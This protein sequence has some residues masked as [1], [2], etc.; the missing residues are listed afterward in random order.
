MNLSP[1]NQVVPIILLFPGDFPLGCNE[2]A[3]IR[4]RKTAL[5]MR[6]SVCFL[7][8]PHFQSGNVIKAPAKCQMV[9][10]KTG[11]CV[12]WRL[13]MLVAFELLVKRSVIWKLYWG[14]VCIGAYI[15]HAI[16]LYIL[17][18]IWTNLVG[19]GP[20]SCLHSTNEKYIEKSHFLPP[21]LR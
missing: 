13:I 11:V 21:C 20:N 7:Q 5:S 2:W 8:C 16:I 18:E 1:A 4:W 19:L 17:G 6:A 14:L 10:L 3:E 15:Y 12:S 9:S